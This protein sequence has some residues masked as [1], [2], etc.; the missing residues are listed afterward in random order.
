GRIVGDIA[1]RAARPPIPGAEVHLS[2]DL[3]LQRF[4]HSIFPRDHDGAVVAIEPR[5]G[6]VLAL[7]SHPA[8]DPNQL[9]GGI[10]GSLWAKLNR[11]S[12]KPLLNRATS[13]IYP[14]G[15]TWKLATAIVGLEKEVIGPSTK[16]PIGCTGG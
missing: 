15:S 13:G 11:D 4:I 10:S 6:E 16:M 8:Y 3:E 9:I 2:I 1:P 7:Y 14:P 12:R 5:T